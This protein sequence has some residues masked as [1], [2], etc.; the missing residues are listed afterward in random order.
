MSEKVIRRENL[1]AI[2]EVA[3]DQKSS[4]RDLPNIKADLP[5]IGKR[6]SFLSNFLE[7]ESAQLAFDLSLERHPNAAI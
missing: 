5:L 2:S 1:G 3:R 4:L 6:T 7:S